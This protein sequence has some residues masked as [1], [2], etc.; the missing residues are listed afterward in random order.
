MWLAG[1]EAVDLAFGDAAVVPAASGLRSPHGASEI[2][3]NLAATVRAFKTY[4]D[5]REGFALVC[6]FSQPLVHMQPGDLVA[7]ALARSG[8]T[9]VGDLDEVYRSCPPACA[10][11]APHAT[12]SP[13]A[14]NG[15]TLALP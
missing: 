7:A 10:G 12:P 5:D 15:A 3:P 13:T 8:L 1:I 4:W 6:N 9:G 14:S 2:T 11:M